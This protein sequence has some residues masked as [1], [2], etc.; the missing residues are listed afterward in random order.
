[1][2]AVGLESLE[3]KGFEPLVNGR[4]LVIEYLTKMQ[5]SSDGAAQLKSAETSDKVLA[6]ITQ[7]QT[8]NYHLLSTAGI[9]RAE[10]GL[11]STYAASA[12]ARDNQTESPTNQNEAEKK[13]E[14]T[15]L[16]QQN[17]T[18]MPA[19]ITSIAYGM[20]VQSLMNLELAQRI[21]MANTLQGNILSIE[22]ARALTNAGKRRNF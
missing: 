19:G 14:E 5:V 6:E 4:P 18:E 10:L 15:F 2:T 1:M 17:L 7:A 20:R 12:L 8:D 3:L 9:A 11:K 16:K 21:N 13:A 22:A